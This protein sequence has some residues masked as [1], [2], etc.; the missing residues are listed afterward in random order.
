MTTPVT[1]AVEKLYTNGDIVP[2]AGTYMCIV[3]ELKISFT[4][5]QV[6]AGEKFPPCELCHAGTEGGPTNVGE[7]FWQ[8]IA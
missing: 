3:C 1:Q 4:E 8:K 7:D 6:R 2:S 5:D